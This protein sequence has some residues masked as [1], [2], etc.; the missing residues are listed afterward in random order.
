[1]RTAGPESAVAASAL[2]TLASVC[3]DL[4]RY[5]EALAL[6][7]R[8]RQIREKLFGAGHPLIATTLGNLAGVLSA[9]QKYAQAEP[10]A[11]RALVI[12][13]WRGSVRIWPR[14]TGN[15]A[16]TEKRN[17]WKLESTRFA[18]GG[19]RQSELLQQCLKPRLAA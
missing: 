11:R 6:L 9:Q 10:L 2:H 14:Y 3:Q 19:P 7:D 18:D 16:A 13:S 5:D 12:P 17:G 1:E 4:K 8:S 15:R